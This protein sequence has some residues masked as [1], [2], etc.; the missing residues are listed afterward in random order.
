MSNIDPRDPMFREEDAARTY[1]ETQRWPDG[2][3]SCV[4]CGSINVHRLEGKTHRDGLI[5]CNDCRLSFTVTTRSVMASTHIPLTKWALAFHKMAG[6]KKCISAKQMQRELNLGSYQT[7]WFLTTRIREVMKLPK[8]SQGRPGGEAKALESD[9][10][11]VGGK[12]KKNV[13]RGKPQPKKHA[14]M[15]PG[16]WHSGPCDWRALRPQMPI[17][18]RLSQSHRGRASSLDGRR[19]PPRRASWV[20]VCPCGRSSSCRQRTSRGSQGL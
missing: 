17:A 1:F 18:E 14:L 13:R 2:K 16:R 11:F 19:A 6:S 8:M 3:P 12:K 7:A 10:T 20:L 5:Q 9:E 15:E 4:H